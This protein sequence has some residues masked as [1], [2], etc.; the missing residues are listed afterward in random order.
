ML[1]QY[2]INLYIISELFIHNLFQCYGVDSYSTAKNDNLW[3]I[4]FDSIFCMFLIHYF[5]K[6]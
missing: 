4:L 3:I 6:T 1:Q 5:L 2:S